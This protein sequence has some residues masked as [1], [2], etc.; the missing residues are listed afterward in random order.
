[1]ACPSFVG[2]PFTVDTHSDPGFEA[3]PKKTVV[4]EIPIYAARGVP[5]EK[6]L[7]AAHLLAEYLDNDEDGAADD[8]AVL[9]AMQTARAFLVMWA[10]QSELEMFDSGGGFGQDL[11]GEETSPGWHTDRTQR[12]DAALEEVLHLVTG[13][14]WAQAY[15]DAFATEPDSTLA[16]AMDVARGGRF[17]EIPDPYPDG[18]WY[19]Y[20]DPTCDYGCM[21]AEYHYWTLTSLLGAQA[22][23]ADDID[24][25]WRAPTPEL[26]RTVDIAA[27][28][29]LGDATYATP[30]RLPD[31]D[32]TG[33]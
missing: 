12:F 7:H 3:L 31:G 2:G 1:M 13:A 26:M 23:R 24:E 22:E 11:G 18:A 16:D 17:L 29:L 4:F 5:D 33:I 15:P 14:G 32:Y 10:S 20:D 25:E 9:D 21:V 19:S 6:V 27:T 8:P 28:A 30:A